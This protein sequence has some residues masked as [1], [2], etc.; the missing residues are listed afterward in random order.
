MDSV[1]TSDENETLFGMT[2]AEIFALRNRMARRFHRKCGQKL[3]IEELYSAG[4]EAIT[5]ALHDTPAIEGY[6]FRSILATRLAQAMVRAFR[7]EFKGFDPQ[8]QTGPMRRVSFLPIEP[9][10]AVGTMPYEHTHDLALLLAATDVHLSVLAKEILFA[11]YD[12]VKYRVIAQQHHVS[13][14]TIF[15]SV[16]VSILTLQ[17]YCRDG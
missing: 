7:Q 16:K 15:R 13:E 8:A 14:R 9:H 3:P 10:H 12:G 6:S 2:W 4:N 11:V 5:D 17:K 1:P